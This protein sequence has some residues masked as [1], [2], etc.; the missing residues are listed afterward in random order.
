MAG[1][2]IEI[3]AAGKRY[4]L[5]QRSQRYTTLRETLASAFHRRSDGRQAPESEHWALRDVELAV[6]EGDVVGVV[7]PNGAGKTTLLK[8]VAGITAPTT[9]LVRTRGRVGALLEVGTGFH[10]ELTGRENI[11]LNGAV[12]GMSRRDIARRFADI[13]AFA[14]VEPFLETPLKRYS[15]GMRLRLAFAVAAHLESDIVVVDEVLAVGDAEFQRRCLGKMSELGREGRTVLF[16]SHDMAAVGRLCRRGIWLDQGTVRSDAP[17][18]E[19]VDRYLGSRAQ[20]ISRLELPSCADQPV[21][22]RSVVVTDEQGGRLEL[23]RRDQPFSISLRFVSSERVAALDLAVY[24]LNRQGVRVLDDA[25]LDTGGHS[26]SADEPGEYEAAVRI[27]PVMPAGEYVAGVW[28]GTEHET[29]FDGE[30]LTFELGPAPDDRPQAVNRARVAQP[31]LD[32]TVR[33]R[34]VGAGS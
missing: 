9:G 1:H 20:R 15:S 30:V 7:G 5:G 17:A 32:W 6:E 28:I 23:P 24:V 18:R 8:L 13:V 12:L 26:Q 19:V 27:P 29:F 21:S 11:Y 22:L 2:A 4:R 31:R 3:E 16:V 14:D 25:W 33:R 34:R 10:P